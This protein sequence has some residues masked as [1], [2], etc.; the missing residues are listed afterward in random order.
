MNS[1]YFTK[2]QFRWSTLSGKWIFGVV[3]SLFLLTSGAVLHA[4]EVDRSGPP[5]LGPAPILK[6]PAIQRLQ[7][8]NG[9][10]VVLMEKQIGRASCRERV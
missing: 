1:A 5:K 6:L 8:A 2:F 7:L 3:M 9:L 10:P 4:Q